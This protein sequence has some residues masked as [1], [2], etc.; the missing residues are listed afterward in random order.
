MDVHYTTACTQ[1]RRNRE[2]PGRPALEVLA[3]LFLPQLAIPFLRAAIVC[4]VRVVRVVCVAICDP[5]RSPPGVHRSRPQTDGIHP[6]IHSLTHSIIAAWR[7]P[8]R[9]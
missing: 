5:S 3:P 7:L 1:M 4:V 2:C 6:F 8:E 9:P